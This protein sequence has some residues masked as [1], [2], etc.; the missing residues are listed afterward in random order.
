MKIKIVQWFIGILLIGWFLRAVLSSVFI[1]STPFFPKETFESIAQSYFQA[2]AM[3]DIDKAYSYQ[4]SEK[5]GGKTSK[6]DLIVFLKSVPFTF[7]KFDIVSIECLPISLCGYVRVH[8]T[9]YGDVHQHQ[10][11]YI[12]FQYLAGRWKIDRTNFQIEPTPK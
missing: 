3:G 4:L 11:I 8:G 5:D 6:N 7:S 2:L 12:Y 9:F 10:L 1:P